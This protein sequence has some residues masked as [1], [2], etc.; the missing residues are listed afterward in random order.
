[1]TIPSSEPRS[2]LP[3]AD[4]REGIDLSIV[5]PAFN[6]AARIGPTLDAIRT[7]LPGSGLCAEILVV[8][9]G[10]SDDTTGRVRERIP[11]TPG[12]RLLSNGRNRGKGF[13]IRHGVCESRGS[14]VLLTDADLST[15]IE[16]LDRL[17]PAVRE[18]GCGIAIGSRALDPSRVKIRQGRIR[19]MLGKGFNL[20]VRGLTGLSIRDTQCGF[21]LLDR[22]ALLPVFRMARVDRFSYDVEILYLAQRRRIRIAEVPVIWRNSPQ[23]RVRILLDPLQMLWDLVRMI[24]RD[25]MGGYSEAP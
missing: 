25:R 24:V 21:K 12:L 8:D 16:E 14:L 22:Q 9:D 5:I 23:S 19:E 17:L 4:T 11:A 3:P 7:F 20:L 1:M 18:T 6:E 10:S 2:P 15:P 13:S